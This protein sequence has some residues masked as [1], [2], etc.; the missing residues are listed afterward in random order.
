MIDDS[1]DVAIFLLDWLRFDLAKSTALD[2]FLSHA[3]HNGWMLLMSVESLISVC[4]HTYLPT[5]I[6]N[7]PSLSVIVPLLFLHALSESQPCRIFRL[8]HIPERI[9]AHTLSFLFIFTVQISFYLVMA[10]FG[11]HGFFKGDVSLFL[12]LASG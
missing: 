7:I 11:V 5:Y 3:T 10:F 2:G 1:L 9:P 8:S 12:I 6:P 4:S